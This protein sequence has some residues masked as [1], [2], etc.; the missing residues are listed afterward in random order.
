MKTLNQLFTGTLGY[1]VSILALIVVITAC[2]EEPKK[3]E[4]VKSETEE[5]VEVNYT[6]WNVKAFYPDGKS[7]DV[8]AF[9]S[10]GKSYDIMALQDSNQ[11]VFLDVKAIADDEKLPVKILVNDELFSPVSVINDEGN[12]F[13][14]KAITANGDQ[15]DIKGIRRYGNIVIIKAITK[16]GKYIDLKAVSPDGKLNDIK[17]IK[18]NR[19][20]REMTLNNVSVHAHVKAMHLAPNEAKFV[21]YKLSESSKK[22]RYSTDFKKISWK[23]NVETPD[24][25]TLVVKAIDKEGNQ[26]DVKA[27]QDSE[28]HSF[29]DIK[30]FTKEY[31]LPVKVMH[32]EDEHAPVCAVSSDGLYQLKA[33]SEDNVQYDIKGISRSGRIINIK[34]INENGEF[35]DV[36]AIAPNGKTNYVHGIKIFDKEVEMT[37]KG[38]PVYAHLKALHQ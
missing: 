6:Y 2:K 10:E 3:E 23:L 35:L 9:N 16:K 34:A 32:T 31:I 30:A 8:K 38:H 5:I 25:K 7:I 11:D 37:S 15:L 19:G 36:K 24:G 13:N 22:V 12:T 28:Q 18:I 27:V 29:M 20:E 21:M 33:I 1:Y 17:G 14:L 4:T 26:I